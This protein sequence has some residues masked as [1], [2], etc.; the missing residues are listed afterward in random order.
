MGQKLVIVESPAKAK[1]IKKYLGSSYVVEASMGHVRD[2]PKSQLGVDIENNYEPKY[3]TIRGKGELLSKL[4][5]E[6]KKSDKIYLATD[7]DREGEA[8]AWHLA[9]ALK[10]DEKDKCRIEFNEITK[11]AVKN[12]IKSPR[13]INATLVDA[14]QAR[15]ILDRLVGYEISPILWRKVKWGLSAGRVQSVT[16]KIICDR[17]K[18]IEKF[19]SKEYWTIECELYKE[20]DSQKLNVKLASKG[21]EKVEMNSKEESDNVINELKEK[22]FII[23]KIK[24][25]SKTRKPL[26]PFIT[27]TLQQDAYRKLNFATK[28][29]MSIAQQ[30][31]EGMEIEGHGTVG[32]ITYMRTDSTRIAEEAQINAKEF[33]ESKYGEK[34]YPST[35]R[36]YK[37]KKNIQDAHEAVR[38]SYVEITPEIA[39]KTLKAPQYKLYKLIW[40]RYVASQMESCLLNTISIDIVN[41]DYVFKASGSKVSFDGFRKIY[42]EEPDEEENTLKIP[43]LN[44]GDILQCEKTEGKQHFTQ[45]PAKFSE[46]SL[47]KT[48][49]ENGIGR[50]STY[51]P[52]ITTLL[53]RKY[54]EKD[55]KILEVTE[56][57]NIVNDILSEYF[58]QIVD[59]EFTA[60]M[61][62][63]LDYIEQGQ[64]KWQNIVSEFFTPLK[65]DIEIAEKEIAKIT[66]EDEVTDVECDKCGKLMVIKHGRFGD[67]MACPG[68]PECKNTKAITKELELPCPKCGGKILERRSKKGTRF[69]GCSNYPECDFVSWFEPTEIKCSECGT[70]MLKR[71]SK[72]K[73]DY[74][75]CSN[76]ECKHKEYKV[77]ENREESSEEK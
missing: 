61:E 3:I 24:K 77:E 74:M 50:P 21:K 51:A 12:A 33:I 38:P 44:E 67:F 65:E 16:L 43:E 10:I 13:V 20:G 6:A 63:N 29:T 59:I 52:I 45:P 56:I 57:G 47:V 23:S 73:G 72:T 39:K 28:R 76:K 36:I 71:Y 55:Q 9:K 46:A 1:T 26:P 53:N 17:Q 4:R 49:E 7:P 64:E 18:E 37:S 58:K 32:L 60:Q 75:E 25:S 54:V 30:L 27:S 19:I 62:N 11:T 69:F 8:I 22:E 68:Y 31:Y 2:L 42:D 70:Y 48:L 40:N 66:I 35:P 34:Y 41:G 5:K 15:R 14:Q